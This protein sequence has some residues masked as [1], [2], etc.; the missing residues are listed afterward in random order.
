MRESGAQVIFSS[1]LPFR[2]D[3]VGWNRRIQSIN[4]CLCDWCY[5]Q[6]FGF[7]DN[8]WFYKTPGLTVITQE[9]FISEGQKGS[10]TG[11]SRAHFETFKLDPKGEGVVAGL[12]LLVQRSSSDEDRETSHPPRVKSACSAHSLKCLY[13]SA[14]SMGN[15]QKELEIHV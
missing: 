3:D 14:H 1:L 12:A 4:G 2:G 10:W 9:R 6:G 8:V 11:I 13:T 15:K 5:R 7:F